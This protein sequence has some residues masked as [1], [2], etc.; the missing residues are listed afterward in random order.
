MRVRWEALDARARGLAT[1]LLSRGELE[2]LAAL[3]DAPALAAALRARGFPLAEADSSPAAL[4]LALRRE[5][6]AWLRII[7]RWSAPR[8]DALSVLFEEEDRRSLRALL[9]GAVQGAPVT[10]RLSG[11][12]PTPALPESA[13]RALAA[14]RSPAAIATLL[15]AWG[16]PYGPP[17]QAPASAA[18]PDLFRLELAIDHTFARRAIQAARRDRMLAAY[19]GETIDVEN[20]VTALV[21]A[22]GKSDVVPRD[23]FLAGGARLGVGPFERAAAAANVGDARRSLVRA[24]AGSPLGAG[25][26]GAGDDATSLEEGILRTR[27]ASLRRATRAGP[28]GPGPLLTFWLRA[29]AEVIDL[30]RIIWGVALAAPREALVRDLVSA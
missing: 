19:V 30:H 12:V 29:R 16:H 10:A 20:A 17:L 27:I 21:L 2:R 8:G 7:A 18:Q 6:A 11:L 25:L 9:R 15:T 5:A 1:H 13:L 23:A 22:G 14:L 28:L 24:L 26:A 4:E 3:P